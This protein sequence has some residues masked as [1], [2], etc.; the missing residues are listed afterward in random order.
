MNVIGVAFGAVL[1]LACVVTAVADITRHPAVTEQLHHLGIAPGLG[2]WLGASKIA[3][4]AGVVAGVWSRTV[5]VVVGVL[6]VVYFA[7]A[8]AAH[9][10]VRDRFGRLAPALVLSWTGAVFTLSS[11]AR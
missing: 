10:R 8:I 9:V 4:A 2:P 6:V 5:A 1:L 3:L 11:L 7:G